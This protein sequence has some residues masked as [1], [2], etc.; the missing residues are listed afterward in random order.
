MMM[1]MLILGKEKLNICGLREDLQGYKVMMKQN[2][3]H[4]FPLFLFVWCWFLFLF[5]KNAAIQL[6]YSIL[7]IKKYWKAFVWFCAYMD[8]NICFRLKQTIAENRLILYLL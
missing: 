4:S 3:F 2:P 5:Y 8:T 1:A 6:L 7:Y